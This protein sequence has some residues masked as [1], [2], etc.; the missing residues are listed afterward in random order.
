MQKNNKRKIG[1]LLFKAKKVYKEKGVY[2][3]LRA[4]VKRITIP[5]NNS[6]EYYY[7]KVFRSRRTFA[8]QGETYRYF[9]N[10]YNKTWRNERTVEIPI[11]WGIVKKYKGRNILEVGNVLS[12]YFP[13]IHDIVDKYEKANNVINQD[14]VDFSPS[15]KY[16]LIISVSTLE[17]VG[18]HEIPRDS[19]K[20]LHAIENLRRLLISKGKMVV[21]LPLGYNLELDK[22]IK[23]YEIQFTKRFCLKRISKDNK[24]IEVRWKDV[25]DVRYDHPF[26]Y[27]NGLIIVVI[28]N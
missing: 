20:I 12:H 13:V 7:Y 9:Y 22:L 18:W 14:V 26:N 24:W 21:T 11:V 25:Q 3:V 15:K 4:G 2:S 23:N 27:A 28:E 19:K 10:K 6:L 16:D 17:H 5:L 1:T 8:F